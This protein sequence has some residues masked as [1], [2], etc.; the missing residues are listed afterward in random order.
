MLLGTLLLLEGFQVIL[1]LGEVLQGTLPLQGALQVI[2]HQLAV[3]TLPQLGVQDFHQLGAIH[4]LGGP[5]TP[6]LQ[7]DL[8]EASLVLP[9][10][11]L[12]LPLV[13]G[14]QVS[15]PF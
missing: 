5:A 10:G 1:P 13:R 11:S 6:L 4:L 12:L 3:D 2:P 15:T 8:P 9:E 7:G 14:S